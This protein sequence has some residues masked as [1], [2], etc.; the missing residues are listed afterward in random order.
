VKTPKP[1]ATS[2]P[3]RNST[4]VVF[5]IALLVTAALIV[6]ALLLRGGN[7]PS[8]ASTSEI[9]FSGIPQQGAVLGSPDA[10]VTLIE[11]A[12]VQCPGC[13]VYA[14]D[15]LPTVV[16]EYVRPGKVKAEFRGYPFLGDDSLKGERFLLAAAEQ[17]KMWELMDAFYRNQG[18][19]NSGWLTDD[20]I[21]QLASEIPGLEVDTLF[22]RAQSDELGQAAQ[23]SATDAQ[24]AGVRQTP[25]LLV[26]IG[27]ATPYEIQVATADQVRAALDDALKG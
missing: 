6:V 24:N 23:Q 20:L 4:I 22:A 11:Y 8:A 25:T 12:D 13:R 21:R 2:K 3:S 7:S 14:L 16:D 27:K 15:L 26:Q 17:N 5:G 9:D 18:V 10:K 19:E 1:A